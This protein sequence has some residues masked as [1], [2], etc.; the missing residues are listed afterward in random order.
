MS[1]LALTQFPMLVQTHNK[2]RDLTNMEKKRQINSSSQSNKQDQEGNSGVVMQ[3]P[4][5]AA[6][7]EGQG[8]GYIT[9]HQ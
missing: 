5:K 3:I 6:E 4:Q 2:H 1:P 7:Q 8:Q 9:T